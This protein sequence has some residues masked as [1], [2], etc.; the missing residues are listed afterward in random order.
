MSV[1]S[2]ERLPHRSPG[3]GGDVNSTSQFA[4]IHLHLLYMVRL[5]SKVGCID[6]VCSRSNSE[7]VFENVY[8]TDRQNKK[9]KNKKWM[10]T[11]HFAPI[12]PFCW[13][14]RWQGGVDGG[15]WDRAA[16]VKQSLWGHVWES[17]WLLVERDTLWECVWCAREFMRR[18]N[19][20]W[21]FVG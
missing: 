3:E 12:H 18:V 15:S 4:P 1:S 21:W 8:L 16:P 13:H 10:S 20:W 5:F 17:S 19:V 2:R 14:A 11:S 9:Q 7:L 6:L